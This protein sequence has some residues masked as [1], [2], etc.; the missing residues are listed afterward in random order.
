MYLKSKMLIAIIL[1]VIVSCKKSGREVETPVEVKKTIRKLLIRIGENDPSNNSIPTWYTDFEYDNQNR[2]TREK[3]TIQNIQYIYDKDRLVQVNQ[4][5]ANNKVISEINYDGDKISKIANVN[6]ANNQP[7]YKEELVCFY[8]GD[9]L[10]RVDRKR[11]GNVTIQYTY[12]Y[13]NNKL[14]KMTLKA[15]NGTTVEQYTT[16]NKKNIQY[17]TGFQ[18][19]QLIRL[20]KG[21]PPTLDNILT[22]SVVADITNQPQVRYEQTFSYTYDDD[23]YPRTAT[24]IHTRGGAQVSIYNYTFEYKVIE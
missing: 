6:R 15:I 12:D 11:D 2:L 8:Q 22:R 23:G 14:T 9:N 1:M 3:G 21:Q 10:S 7:E 4:T 16:D 24:R 5:L 13:I 19:L 17:D 18:T 20:L